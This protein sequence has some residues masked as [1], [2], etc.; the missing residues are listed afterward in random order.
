MNDH[1]VDPPMSPRVRVHSGER[2]L[3]QLLERNRAWSASMHAKD[4]NYFTRLSQQQS[5][6]ILW[7]GC[8]D[9]RVPANEIV[10]L[11]PGEIFV[12]RNIA[13]QVIATDMNCLSVLEYAVKYLQV[14]HIIV[15]G[16]YGCG[17]VNAALSQREYGVVDNWLRSIKDLYIKKIETFQYLPDQEAK[18]DLLCEAN[19]ARS[20]YNICHTRIVQKAWEDGHALSVH[21]W[22]YRLEDGIIRDLNTCIS[23]EKQVEAIYR[24]M[25]DKSKPEA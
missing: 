24:R 9:S 15:C 6:D 4:S 16:H 7:I 17:G 13:N 1:S 10:D 19:V 23:S 21:G 22:C 2:G 20:V 3:T 8:S 5:P 14:R 18:S 12:H 11:A 25:M